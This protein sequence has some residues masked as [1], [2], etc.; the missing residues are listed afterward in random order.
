M[1]RHS[2]NSQIFTGIGFTAFF[3]FL[4]IWLHNP[5]IAIPLF[6]AGILPIMKGI[7]RRISSRPTQRIDK[8]R[9]E[10]QPKPL[11]GDE[12]ERLILKCAK[13]NGGVLTPA[14]AAVETELTITTASKIL[15]SM[16]QRGYASMEIRAN[17]GIEYHFSDFK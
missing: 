8:P 10:T 11:S 13:E 14:L 17:G 1:G 16:A 12:Q 7:D 5:F 3:G 15:E 4:A 2:G 6:F 9:R